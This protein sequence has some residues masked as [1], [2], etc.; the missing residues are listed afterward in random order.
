MAEK[1]QKNSEKDKSPDKEDASIKELEADIEKLKLSDKDS[2]RDMVCPI[3][4]DKRVHSVTLPCGHLFCF[5]CIKGVYARQRVCPMCRH[6]IPIDSISHPPSEGDSG[7][8][9]DSP[10]WK[11]QARSEG[12]WLYEERISTELEKSY[13]EGLK[14]IHVQISGFTYIVNFETMTQYRQEKPDRV[15]IIKRETK[16]EGLVR[17]VAGIPM[18]P[19]T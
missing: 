19:P 12:W 8:M 5:L 6:P 10:C 14:E 9:D 3:C 15:R 16:N 13:Q 11:Y 17:G 2:P 7:T 1:L 18:A 4:Q